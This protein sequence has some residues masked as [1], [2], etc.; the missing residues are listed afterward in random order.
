MYV[1]CFILQKFLLSIPGGVFSEVGEE[2]LLKILT[3]G[4]KME[5]YDAVHE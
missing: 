3:I 2:T 4:H 1:N 5:Q